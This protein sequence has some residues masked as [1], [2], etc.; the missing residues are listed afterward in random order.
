MSTDT[1]RTRR[2]FLWLPMRLEGEWRWLRRA[3]VE[4]HYQIYFDSCTNMTQP[5]YDWFP[6][7]WAVSLTDPAHTALEIKDGLPVLTDALVFS[8]GKFIANDHTA[9]FKAANVYHLTGLPGRWQWRK[10]RRLKAL[11]RSFA[12]SAE[13]K[14]TYLPGS[15]D[16]P[17]PPKNAQCANELREA[18]EEVKALKERLALM[19]TYADNRGN[20]ILE[21]CLTYFVTNE[22]MALPW[23]FVKKMRYRGCAKELQRL[24]EVMRGGRTP[25][26]QSQLRPHYAEGGPLSNHQH[27]HVINT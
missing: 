22:A 27:Q 13:M 15:Y 14:T 11:L 12:G 20:V 6:R 9:A 4:E 24:R 5:Q 3:T 23:Q 2:L 26:C 19:E 8:R 21:T 25:S 18:R 7:R 1:T 16:R 10:W 17:E